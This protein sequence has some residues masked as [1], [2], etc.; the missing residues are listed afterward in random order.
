MHTA[1]SPVALRT[2][3]ADSVHSQP[4]GNEL[5]NLVITKKAITAKMVTGNQFLRATHHIL[6]S[7]M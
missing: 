7:N 2:A 4:L 1:H 5:L 6:L 3:H